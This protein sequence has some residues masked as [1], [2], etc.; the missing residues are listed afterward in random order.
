[1]LFEKGRNVRE[2]PCIG[3]SRMNESLT[4][5]GQFLVLKFIFSK[6]MNSMRSHRVKWP[7]NLDSVI[8][9]IYNS[10]AFWVLHECPSFHHFFESRNEMRP[11]WFKSTPDS[12]LETPK[13][14]RNFFLVWWT[15]P[16]FSCACVII[17]HT[18]PNHLSPETYLL[19]FSY[20]WKATFF[21]LKWYSNTMA[22]GCF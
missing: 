2:T 13:K 4:Y 10:F 18:Y 12:D 3:P 19:E 16:F 21:V 6:A 5:R 15:R 20:F 9:K 22:M 8:L 1:M 7:S 11:G 17:L 14:Y